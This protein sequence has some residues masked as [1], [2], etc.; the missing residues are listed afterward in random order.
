MQRDWTR[1]ARFRREGPRKRFAVAAMLLLTT[2]AYALIFDIDGAT[3][4][5]IRESQSAMEDVAAQMRTAR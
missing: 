3:G 4:G 1:M 2:M 5:G